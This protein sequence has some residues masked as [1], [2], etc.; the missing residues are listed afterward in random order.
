MVTCSCGKPIEKI[1]DWMQSITVEFVCN[2]CPNR[3]HKNIA[4]V[5]LEAALTTAVKDSTE[6]IPD[7]EGEDDTED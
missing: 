5:N 6:E 1:P 3:Q 2:N 7:L 4:F